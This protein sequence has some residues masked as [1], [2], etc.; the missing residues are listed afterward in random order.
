MIAKDELFGPIQTYV[1]DMNIEDAKKLR[2]LSMNYE[3]IETF[4]KAW[5]ES[6]STM[7]LMC[8]SNM[9]D[10]KHDKIG[11]PPTGDDE[12]NRDIEKALEAQLE[13]L[14]NQIAML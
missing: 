3:I 11:P 1:N 9:L 13:R 4:L 5:K 6:Q 12:L 10:L 8:G 2:T 14:K 7:L